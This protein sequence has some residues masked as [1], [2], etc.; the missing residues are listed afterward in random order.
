MKRY[1]RSATVSDDVMQILR[2]IYRN[3][4]S[5]GRTTSQRS[6]DCLDRTLDL[7]K[8]SN[9]PDIIL[10]DNWLPIELKDI[11]GKYVWVGTRGRYSDR[12]YSSIATTAMDIAKD[13][14]GTAIDFTDDTQM[15]F[16]FIPD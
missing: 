4:F 8:Y 13:L 3:G 2:Q 7:S 11:P 9:D 15:F 1:I 16:V 10:T 6:N 5:I 14:G 12:R